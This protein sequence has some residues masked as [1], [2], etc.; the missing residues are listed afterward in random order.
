MFEDS[1]F[2]RDISGW[3]VSNVCFMYHM[4]NR[5]PFNQDISGWNVS[6]VFIDRYPENPGNKDI[7]GNCTIKEKYKPI[8]ARKFK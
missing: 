7:F 5:S 3:D 2:N 4:F 6:N 1:I 8:Q